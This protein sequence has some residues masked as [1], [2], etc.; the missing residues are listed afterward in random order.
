MLDEIEDDVSDTNNPMLQELMGTARNMLNTT[1]NMVQRTFPKDKAYRFG[2]QTGPRPGPVII[3]ERIE[4]ELKPKTIYMGK[5]QHQKKALPN[6]QTKSLLPD[7]L[8][9]KGRLV[10]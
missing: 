3:Q 2:F 9:G 4:Q 5:I 6:P 7:C 10:K 1:G 8:R